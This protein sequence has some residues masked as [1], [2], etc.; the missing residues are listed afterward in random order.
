MEASAPQDIGLLLSLGEQIVD[1]PFPRCVEQIEDVLVQLGT[2]T[3]NDC[4]HSLK[5]NKRNV[6]KFEELTSS[7]RSRLQV[8]TKSPGPRHAFRQAQNELDLLV[9]QFEEQQIVHDKKQLL[10]EVLHEKQLLLNMK[11]RRLDI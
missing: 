9:A 10:A 5:L 8:L 1:I 2:H 7:L 4:I 11:R 3:I 6:A